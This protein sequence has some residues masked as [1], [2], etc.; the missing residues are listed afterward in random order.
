[1]LDIIGSIDFMKFRR[2]NSLFPKLRKLDWTLTNNR[3]ICTSNRSNIA[4]LVYNQSLILFSD[5]KSQFSWLPDFLRVCIGRIRPT[6][7]PCWRRTLLHRELSCRQR[8]ATSCVSSKW[9]FCRADGGRLYAVG[10]CISTITRRYSCAGHGANIE[11]N[12]SQS[13]LPSAL[14]FRGRAA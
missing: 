2:L 6:D 5:H 13:A 3:L 10:R 9:S 7:L 11:I 8:N 12:A 14:I 1:M 4:K